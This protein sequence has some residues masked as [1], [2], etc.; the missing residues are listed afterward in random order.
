[1]FDRARRDPAFA[2]RC[3]AAMFRGED[4]PRAEVGGRLL[5]DFFL[6]ARKFESAYLTTKK[7][8]GK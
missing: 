8:N 4:E 3:L 1:M 5:A 7:H 2:G 6:T